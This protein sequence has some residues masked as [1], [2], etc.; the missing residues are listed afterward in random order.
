MAKTLN[1]KLFQQLMLVLCVL[2]FVSETFK[3]KQTIKC[4]PE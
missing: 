1:Q 3:E 2:R 4:L